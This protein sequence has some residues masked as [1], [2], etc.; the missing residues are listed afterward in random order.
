VEI[1]V[2]TT[3]EAPGAL[4]A[5]VR[6]LLTDAFDGSF[7][8]DDWQHTLGGWHVIGSDAGAVVSHAAVVA[9]RIDVGDHSFAAGY[10]EGVATRPDRQRQGLGSLVMTRAAEVIRREFEL[11]VLSTD[12]PELYRHVGWERWQGP[13][14]ART[15]GRLVRTDDEDDGIL[16]LRFGPSQGVDLTAAIS[17]ESRQGD[18]W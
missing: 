13:T 11:G 14:F 2:M 9:R 10:V 17:C 6:L 3:D 1:R 8:D 4:L 12:R 5:E 18:D 16:V 7:S 15:D